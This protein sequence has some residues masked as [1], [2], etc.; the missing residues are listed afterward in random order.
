MSKLSVI[1]N[2]EQNTEKVIQ[3]KYQWERTE[4]SARGGLLLFAKFF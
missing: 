4:I 3:L 2:F 1:L